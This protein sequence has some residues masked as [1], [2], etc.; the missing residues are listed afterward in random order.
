MAIA[1]LFAVSPALA[2]APPESS[3]AAEA[4]FN[5]GMQL[6]DAG[7]FA[8][9]CPKLAESHRIDP[10]AGAV[11]NAGDCYEHVGRTASA[12][13]AFREAELRW[14]QRSDGRADEAKKRADM[15]EPKLSKLTIIV[16]AVARAPG[17]V[18]KRNGIELGEAQWST[19]VPVDP[20]VVAIEASAPERETWKTS[21]PVAGAGEITIELP[22]LKALPAPASTMPAM[23][24]PTSTAE[25]PLVTPAEF[26]S[27][28]RKAGSV[29]GASGV[30]VLGVGSGL[31]LGAADKVSSAKKTECNE[32]KVCT[33]NGAD[34]LANAKIEGTASTTLFIA[35]AMLAAG[36]VIVMLT[37]PPS[38][39][40]SA[41]SSKKQG[42]L[43]LAPA[44]GTT[45]G[46]AAGGTW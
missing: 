16:P 22:A 31:G 19:G 27:T 24:A 28:Q 41:T 37:A 32:A 6:M 25:A 39:P 5:Q 26:W 17:L 35:G 34:L 33:R 10:Q 13:G 12:W 14:R 7:N 40:A 44:L 29:L 21:V 42:T 11:F 4:L 18:V 20:A 45:W 43:W 30:V 46:L 9:A 38:A 1:W 3:A 2:Q 36:G 8:E 15:L 23:V